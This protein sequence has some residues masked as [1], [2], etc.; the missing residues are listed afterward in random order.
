MLQ[1]FRQ[2]KVVTINHIFFTPKWNLFYI[3]DSSTGLCVGYVLKLPC[4]HVHLLFCFRVLKSMIVSKWSMRSNSNREVVSGLFITK[5]PITIILSQFMSSEVVSRCMKHETHDIFL[6]F[7]LF[8]LYV[9]ILY[10]KFSS[11]INQLIIKI[12][13]IT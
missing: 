2:R 1:K 11:W 4:R 13:I 5:V 6:Y 7:W 10:I 9:I 12:N 8:I 3:W